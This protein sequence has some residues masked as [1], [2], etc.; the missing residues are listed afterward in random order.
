MLALCKF[1]TKLL[2]SINGG[3]HL[4]SKV[5]LRLSE[6]RDNIMHR[7][8]LSDNHDV[9]VTARGFGAGCDRAVDERELDLGGESSE[10]AL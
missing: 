7:N 1:T 5:P 2:G 4:S 3:V 10:T 6:G 8:P 9:Y